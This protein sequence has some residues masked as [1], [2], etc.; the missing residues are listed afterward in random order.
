MQLS[1]NMLVDVLLIDERDFYV[2]SKMLSDHD[3][4]I[5]EM[6][7]VTDVPVESELF[8]RFASL[9]EFHDYVF[10]HIRAIVI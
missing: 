9:S 3:P 1:Q 7:Y 5:H 10:T 8:H 6:G 4:H 2:R